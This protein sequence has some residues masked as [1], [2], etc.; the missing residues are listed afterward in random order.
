MCSLREAFSSMLE[1]KNNNEARDNRA[2]LSCH[3]VTAQAGV[4]GPDPAAA[5]APDPLPQRHVGAGWEVQRAPESQ[6][7]KL[8][9][10]SGREAR[11]QRGQKAVKA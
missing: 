3:P 2:E 8:E 5:G 7:V 9:G 11:R 4:P 10:I 1:R 6:K